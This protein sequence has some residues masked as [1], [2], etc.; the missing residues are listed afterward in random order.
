MTSPSLQ[1]SCGCL[2]NRRRPLHGSGL[3]LDFSRASKAQRLSSCRKHLQ[4]QAAA[5]ERPLGSSISQQGLRSRHGQLSPFCGQQV[6]PQRAHT[7]SCAALPPFAALSNFWHSWQP[8]QAWAAALAVVTAV[9]LALK[10]IF[11][12]PSRAYNAN[13]GDVYDDW[14]DEGV[15]EYFWG[16][17]IHLGYYSSDEQKKAWKQPIWTGRH[18]KDFKQAKFDFI[19]EMLAW[20]EA[21]QPPTILDVGCGIGGTTRHLAAKFPNS[22]V[23]GK[24]KV[25]RAVSI[26]HAAS[27]QSSSPRK[28]WAHESDLMSNK[29]A[30]VLTFVRMFMQG[31]PDG[32]CIVVLQPLQRCQGLFDDVMMSTIKKALAH[33]FC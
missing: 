13:V 11:D 15:L 29:K 9:F 27:F 20:S 5:P 24:H 26:R 14:T 31:I 17:H 3:S 1:H 6:S 28:L 8:W 12:T 33:D 22:K 25:D 18:P 30:R 19:D 4:A 32:G 21:D 7:L 23:T 2:T 16:E 10:R